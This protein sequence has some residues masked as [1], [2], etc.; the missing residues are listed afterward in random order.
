[1]ADDFDPNSPVDGEQD[2][3][4]SPDS[5]RSKAVVLIRLVAGGFLLIGSLDL[6]LYLFQCQRSH[7]QPGILHCL[8][9]GL[10]L[11]IGIW[12]L[13]RTSALA[14]RIEEWLEQ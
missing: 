9:L 3:H 13:A 11:V 1:M 7:S 8:W 6:G 2:E 5:F 10:P 4:K 14:D 12:I